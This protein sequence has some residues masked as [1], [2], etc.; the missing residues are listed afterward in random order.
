M[1]TRVG[2]D[3][4]T[5]RH[6]DT[7]E[8][9]LEGFTRLLILTAVDVVDETTETG[10]IITDEKDEASCCLRALFRLGWEK[11]DEVGRRWELMQTELFWEKFERVWDIEEVEADID[12][13]KG[14]NLA[15]AILTGKICGT[16]DVLDEVADNPVFPLKLNGFKSDVGPITVLVFGTYP[17]AEG[18][19]AYMSQKNLKVNQV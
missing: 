18:P 8:F 10:V 17:T 12:G 5:L 9:K 3:G 1:A 4:K 14:V 7:T 6:P 11:I 13:C 19:L 2:V 15:G 16:T